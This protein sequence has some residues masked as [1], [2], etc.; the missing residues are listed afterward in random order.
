MIT[1]EGRGYWEIRRE[2]GDICTKKVIIDLQEAAVSTQAPPRCC[3][4]SWQL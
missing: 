3:V 2:A 1:R 4:D